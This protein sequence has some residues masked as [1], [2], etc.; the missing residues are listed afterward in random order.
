MDPLTYSWLSNCALEPFVGALCVWILFMFNVY[1]HD[2]RNLDLFLVVI[3]LQELLSS[4]IVF[5]YSII[6]LI[7]AKSETACN[8]VM[9]GLIA[10]RIF[11]MA[12]IC[13]LAIDRALIIKWPYKYRFSVRQNQILY[14]IVVLGLMS[15]LVGIA[16]I[17]A[18]LST[19]EISL[20]LASNTSFIRTSY[21]T[22]NPT[23]WNIRFNIFFTSIAA[24]LTLLTLISFIYI[25]LNRNNDQQLKSKIM[26]KFRIPSYGDLAMETCGSTET[27]TK[28]NTG[29]CQSLQGFQKLNKEILNNQKVLLNH[30]QL[31]DLRWS[32]VVSTTSLSYAI[33]QGPFL[34]SNN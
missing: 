11:Q 1:R 7:R 17:F 3:V 26:P 15:G 25:E 30:L 31:P 32:V 2:W 20:K 33:N 29:S 10:F 4:L 19:N 21:C 16:G 34:V 23:L 9:W 5:A 13:S 6:N 22:L 28:Y 12:T 14:H 8:I 27:I 24:F 18:R